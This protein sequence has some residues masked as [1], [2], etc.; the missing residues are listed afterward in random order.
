MLIK[1]N[2]IDV[3]KK[4]EEVMEI[5]S[6][7]ET[8]HEYCL[9]LPF[10]EEL[11]IKLIFDI[12]QHGLINPI[13]RYNGKILDGRHRW[14]ACNILGILPTQIELPLSIDP[15][16][17]VESNNLNRRHLSAGQRVFIRLELDKWRPKD[18]NGDTVELRREILHT[19]RLAKNAQSKP[20]HVKKAKKLIKHASELP[21]I[22]YI[23]EQIKENKIS[24]NTGY[25]AIFKSKS[26]NQKTKIIKE[27][28]LHEF[29]EQKKELTEKFSVLIKNKE[30]IQSKYD[31]LVESL[32]NILGDAKKNDSREIDKRFR[33]LVKKLEDLI[34]EID[35]PKKKRIF[36]PSLK[37]L[38]KAELKIN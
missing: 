6:E 34:N 31:R 4:I 17:Y 12:K 13:A 14:Y 28:V 30:L 36:L 21:K 23:I 37:D 10:Q 29:K 22:K 5:I 2:E 3:R 7:N 18:F 35:N 33:D 24:L 16:A 25:N 27:D 9:V 38:R 26:K 19:R 32:K 20:I 11:V 8:F 1:M 15:I